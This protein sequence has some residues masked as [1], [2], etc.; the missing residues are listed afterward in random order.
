MGD[1]PEFNAM[2]DEMIKKLLTTRRAPC[3]RGGRG[4]W[5]SGA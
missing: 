4:P 1:E 2:V 3:T 5:G